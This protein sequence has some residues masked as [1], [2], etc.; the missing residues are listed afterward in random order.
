[1]MSSRRLSGSVRARDHQVARR[2]TGRW[3]DRMDVR[4]RLTVSK[5]YTVSELVIPEGS[6]FI[7]MTI[8]EAAFTA[9]DIN[10]LTLYRGKT[11][12]PNPKASRTLEGGDR[13][14]KKTQKKREP[15]LQDL[16]TLMVDHATGSPS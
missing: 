12:I 4:Q 16:N 7:G 10:V 5:G 2:N 15:K 11:V 1:M 8:P 6:H 14:P 9:Q 3:R 13:L